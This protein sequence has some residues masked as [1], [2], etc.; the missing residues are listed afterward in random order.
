MSKGNYQIPFD[1]D[2]NLLS[3][4]DG[5]HTHEWRDNYTFEAAM[6]YG[7]YGRGRSSAVLYWRDEAGHRYPMFMSDFDDMMEAVGIT[8]REVLGKWTFT[9]KGE[10]YGLQYVKEE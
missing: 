7:G 8:Y 2:G 3:Y 1:K 9:K 10:N 6:L 5:W 4:D